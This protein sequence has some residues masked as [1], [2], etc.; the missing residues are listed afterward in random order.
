VSDNNGGIIKF[1]KTHKGIIL[2]GCI[3][4]IIGALILW[5]GFFRTLFLAICVGIGVFLGSNNRF[6]KRLFEI[7][8]RILPDIFK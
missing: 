3:G 2:G 8:D 6:R 1:I 7:L 5:I 4:F